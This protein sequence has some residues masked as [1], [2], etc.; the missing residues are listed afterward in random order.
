MA[1]KGQWQGDMWAED[2]DMVAA[3]NEADVVLMQ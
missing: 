1:N 2:G 3:L